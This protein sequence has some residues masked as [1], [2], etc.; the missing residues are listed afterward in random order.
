MSDVAEKLPSVPLVKSVC[1]LSSFFNLFFLAE[2][3]MFKLSLLFFFLLVMMLLVWYIY[4]A[5]SNLLCTMV[6]LSVGVMLLVNSSCF[7][8]FAA[9]YFLIM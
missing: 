4:N 6:G 8:L 7:F 1:V 3:W 9:F 5:D 2:K